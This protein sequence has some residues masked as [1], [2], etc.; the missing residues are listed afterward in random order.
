MRM[1]WPA[2]AAG[3]AVAVLG[4]AGLIRGAMPQQ[5]PAPAPAAAAAPIV[6]TGAYVRQPAPPTDAA[7]AYFTAY[8]TTGVPDRLVAV[9]SGAGQQAVLHTGDMDAMTQGALVPAHGKLV[10]ATGKGHVMIEK[11]IGILRPGQ[12]V[13]LNLTFADAGVISVAAPVVALGAPVPVGGHS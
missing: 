12:V 2:A 13:D 4:A 1:P 3:V 10:L 8:N 9:S 7:A 11:L 6:V 5:V